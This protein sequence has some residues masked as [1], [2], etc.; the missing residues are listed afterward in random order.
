M[1]LKKKFEN[2]KKIYIFLSEI[3]FKLLSFIFYL[4]LNFHVTRKKNVFLI[5]LK[6]KF[7]LNTP[8]DK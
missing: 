4:Q 7:V 5:F 2:E 6:F 1:L 8:K 3:F